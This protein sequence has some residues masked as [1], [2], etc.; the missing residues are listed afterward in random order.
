MTPI[1]DTPPSMLPWIAWNSVHEHSKDV[2]AWELVLLK[3]CSFT[4]QELV[5]I[6]QLNTV[7]TTGRVSSAWPDQKWGIIL[8][9]NNPSQKIGQHVVVACSAWWTILKVQWNAW[10]IKFNSQENFKLWYMYLC[11]LSGRQL[12][13]MSCQRPLTVLSMWRLALL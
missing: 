4:A 13:L 2:L 10:V 5:I 9:F 1:I 11:R 6:S 7:L 8:F 3:V 12:S